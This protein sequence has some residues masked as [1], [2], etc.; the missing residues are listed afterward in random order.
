MTLPS[1][2]LSSHPLKMNDD[3]KQPWGDGESDWLDLD[4]LSPLALELKASV[5]QA[6]KWTIIQGSDSIEK[7]SNLSFC[8]KNGLRFHFDYSPIHSLCRYVLF[9]L[10]LEVERDCLGSRYLQ[11]IF[12][13]GDPGLG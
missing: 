9:K 1:E 2:L 6:G 7:I 8:L 10:P 4:S 12:S 11:G 3:T 13:A 5:V